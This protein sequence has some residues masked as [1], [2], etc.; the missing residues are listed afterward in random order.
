MTA[1]ATFEKG[2]VV[3]IV[4]AGTLS[5]MPIDTTEVILT[6]VD[7]AHEGGI[8][9]AGPGAGNIDPK[10]GAAYATGAMIPYYP[11]NVGTQF[12]TSN[13]RSDAGAAVVVPA[14]TDIGEVYEISYA[15]ANP[16]LGWG[17]DQT[18]ATVAT[19]VGARILD[20]LDTNRVSINEP[21]SDGTGVFLVFTITL[22]D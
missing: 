18:N 5:E 12:I 4:N 2:E 17:V 16:P 11:W 15:T 3:G 21:G 7:T 8:S 22:A 1:A 19:E 20:V 14:L 13:F 9:A 10:T 6:D